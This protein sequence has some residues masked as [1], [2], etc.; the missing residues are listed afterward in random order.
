MERKE[1]TP[2]RIRQRRYETVHKEER[3]EQNKVWG[4]SIPRKTAEEIDDFLAKYGLTKV[5]L[6]EVGYKILKKEFE[7]K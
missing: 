6:I 2:I 4:T 3:K 5:A 7:G 1:D